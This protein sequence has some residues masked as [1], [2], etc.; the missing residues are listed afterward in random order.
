MTEIC[1]TEAV[2][3]FCD[4][5]FRQKTDRCSSS[6]RKIGLTTRKSHVVYRGK[7]YLL[8]GFSMKG[9][10]NEVQIVHHSRQQG[11]QNVMRMERA[12]GFFQAAVFQGNLDIGVLPIPY[13]FKTW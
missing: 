6:V 12:R 2:L 13:W 7:L 4:H 5:K 10:T 3:V 8:G 9:P 1:E 11:W